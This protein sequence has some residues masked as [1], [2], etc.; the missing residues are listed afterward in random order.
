MPISIGLLIIVFGFLAPYLSDGQIAPLY[1]FWIGFLLLL[2]PGKYIHQTTRWANDA[3]LG[4]LVNILAWILYIILFRIRSIP[5]LSNNGVIHLAFR[6]L[7][8]M[9]TFV[10]RLCNLAFPIK[11]ERAPDGGY[12]GA[13]SFYRVAITSFLHLALYMGAFILTG[14]FSKPRLQKS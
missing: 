13:I 5:C 9:V 2:R 3:R 11:M 6:L 1:F 8:W 4:L 7:M 14:V 10:T 12:I